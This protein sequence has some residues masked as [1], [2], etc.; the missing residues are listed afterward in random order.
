MEKRLLKLLIK[1]FIKSLKNLNEIWIKEKIILRVEEMIKNFYELN[2]KYFL[3]KFLDKLYID[4]KVLFI[5]VK[6][7]VELYDM[8]MLIKNNFLV[9][10]VNILEGSV[11]IIFYFVKKEDFENYLSKFSRYD[12]KLFK[13]FFKMILNKIF[14]EIFGVNY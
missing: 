5:L 8:F 3:E 9:M 6:C 4:K 12:E 10:E 11:C 2:E 14:L 13:D 1:I 7:G